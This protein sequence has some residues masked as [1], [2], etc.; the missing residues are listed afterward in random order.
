MLAIMDTAE[1]TRLAREAEA[2][3]AKGSRLSREDRLLLLAWMMLGR[4]T[5]KER[6]YGQP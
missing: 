5:R 1:L 3:A 4:E 2:R 6:G